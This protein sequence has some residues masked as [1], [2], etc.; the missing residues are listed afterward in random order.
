MKME[1]LVLLNDD[2]EMTA[3]DGELVRHTRC[4]HCDKTV[5]VK[6]IFKK[7][8]VVCPFCKGKFS[9]RLYKNG[10]VTMKIR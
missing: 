4:F 6:E 1:E 9:I 2:G 5:L 3:Q 8:D 10:R 7:Q